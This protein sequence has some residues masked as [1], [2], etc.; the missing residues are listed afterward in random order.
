[1]TQNWHGRPLIS[2]GVIINL[3]ANTQIKTGLKIR[4]ALDTGYYQTGMKISDEEL[5]KVKLKIVIL[6]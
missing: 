6:W 3:I 5:Q 1:M 4:A 2:H